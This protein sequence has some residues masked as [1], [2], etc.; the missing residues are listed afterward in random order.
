MQQLN[1]SK[2]TFELSDKQ[3]C[4]VLSARILELRSLGFRSFQL[5]NKSKTNNLELFKNLRNLLGFGSEDLDFTL[6]YSIVNNYNNG[7]GT[8]ELFEKYIRSIQALDNST[9]PKNTQDSVQNKMSNIL[10]VSGSQKRKIDSIK[11]LEKLSSTK[12]LAHNE[13]LF[14]ANV[15]KSKFSV[16][17]NPYYKGEELE[18]EK[19][20]LR[21][22]VATGI[23]DK[24]YFQIGL[25]MQSM[26]SGITFVKSLR[27]EFGYA[28][29]V[30]ICILWP[31]RS[32]L[33]SWS[34]RP[35]GGV[36]L[37][38]EYLGSVANSQNIAIE[39]INFAQSLELGI[40][41]TVFDWE[42]WLTFCS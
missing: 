40:L 26:Q 3:T 19:T 4:E 11:V 5:T 21:A 8:I 15:S 23:I 39:Q 38:Q 25:D 36:F 29:E 32:L 33:N 22:K 12:Y 18:A 9:A 1:Q 41:I 6:T 37:T 31:S 35:W 24:I 30:V 2:I 16:A 42:S 13:S 34:F 7:E 28:M 17:F 14:M 20:R 10:I 27:L